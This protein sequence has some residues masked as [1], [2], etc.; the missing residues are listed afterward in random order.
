MAQ[1][2]VELGRLGSAA[3]ILTESTGIAPVNDATLDTLRSKH[4][5]GPI[6]PF[7]LA[8]PRNN[9]QEI[10]MP[11]EADIRPAIKSFDRETGPGP[12]GWTIPLVELA[13]ESA[14][15]RNALRVLAGLIANGTAP[16]R[17]MLCAARLTPLL[18]PNGGIRPIA[19][20]EIFYRICAKAI[21]R[22]NFKPDCVLPY[23][24][25]VGSKGG[26]EPIPRAIELAINN[27]LTRKFTHLACLDFFNA[28]NETCRITTA[29]AIK[30]FSPAL[31]RAADWAY[32]DATPL[33]VRSSDNTV[34]V[35]WSAQGVRQGD[36]FAAAFFSVAFRQFLDDLQEHLGPDHTII[37]YLDDVYI[38]GPN[39]SILDKVIS[40][41]SQPEHHAPAALNRDKCHV[42]SL[43]A[44]SD[45]G[46]EMLGTYVGPKTGRIKF[47]ADRIEEQ[48]DVL[49]RLGSLPRQHALLL[50]RSSIQLNLR[51]LLRSLDSTEI[52]HVWSRL[53]ELIQTAL[54]QIRGGEAVPPDRRDI[55]NDLVTLPMRLGG[56][57]LI[58]FE[59][60]A[61]HARA[62]S[63]ES[64]DIVLASLFPSLEPPDN[65]ISQRDRCQEVFS[66][67]RNHLFTKLNLHEKR[68][69][70]ENT[71]QLSR[72]WMSVIPSN[73]SAVLSDHEVQAGLHTRTLK[74]PGSHC[75][76][77]ARPYSASHYDTCDQAHG[78]AT[79]R[80]ESIKYAL[81]RAMQ[82]IPGITV[83]YEPRM[84]FVKTT[85]ERRNDLRIVGA[86][87]VGIGTDEIDASIPSCCSSRADQFIRGHPP[88]A[89][90]DPITAVTKSIDQYLNLQADNK[91]KNLP[92]NFA[93]NVAFQPIII[94]PGGWLKSSTTEAFK[95]YKTYMG[96]ET[97]G[98]M[99]DMISIKLV[100]S[101]S[102][103]LKMVSTTNPLPGRSSSPPPYTYTIF[104]LA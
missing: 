40:F 43:A 4:P 77:C 86:A 26:V 9:A 33:Y 87:D 5:T 22:K 69:V 94:S 68:R 90:L 100:R 10:S 76:R 6:D 67:R 71:S 57:G 93:R 101:R 36:P 63:I 44:I 54:G 28:F 75:T 85:R 27:K 47:L 58:S 83:T 102:R 30:R 3:R 66:T 65:P 99:L 84:G 25:G 46:L 14:S 32:N 74:S 34:H 7:S 104:P 98:W 73:R 97:Y 48:T 59:E 64:S 19:G 37:A 8:R 89:D 41:A 39:E 96:Q 15:F 53:D 11:T 91:R 55:D 17:Q 24:L 70:I 49:S 18:K 21:L 92:D 56:L 81:A 12:S 42:T 23:Q 103:I 35:I 60:C 61:K 16:G 51:H 82:R 95:K 79:V 88:P 80:H 38:L 52:E 1:K 20:G 62:A 45:N 78:E 72:R 2:Q 50:L 13:F 31:F 29:N